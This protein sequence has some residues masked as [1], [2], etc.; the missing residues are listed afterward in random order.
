MLY[1]F[2]NCGCGVD[3]P[4]RLPMIV[5]RARCMRAFTNADSGVWRRSLSHPS[6]VS[7]ST[8][9]VSRTARPMCFRNHERKIARRAACF[10]QVVAGVANRAK[11]WCGSWRA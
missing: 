4:A 3:L 2:N 5:R 11:V 8:R 1:A 9:R 7:V 10:R 6:S